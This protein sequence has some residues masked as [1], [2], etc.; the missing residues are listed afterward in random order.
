MMLAEDSVLPESVWCEMDYTNIHAA[1]LFADIQNSVMI[2]STASLCEYDKLINDF[3]AAMLE[4]VRALQEQGVAIGEYRVS[5]DELCLFIYDP[6]EVERN[7]RLDGPAPL[8][9]AERERVVQLSRESNQQLLISALKAA[10][11]L[12]SHWLVQRFNVQ[13]VQSHHAPFELCIG[14]HDGRVILRDRPDGKRRIEGYAVNLAKR[15]QSASRSARYSCIMLSEDACEA[16][17]RSVVAHSQ[18]RQRVFFH[19]HEMEL[20]EM[21]GVAKP[22]PVYELKF[23][24][25]IH[26]PVPPAS[27][28]LHEA[29]FAIDPTCLWS[30]YQL[31]EHHAYT[32]GNWDEAYTIASRAHTFQPRDEKIKLDLA[33]Y[34]FQRKD[35]QMATM[36]CNQAL[37]LNPE[38]DLAYELM[39]LIAETLDDMPAAVDHLRQAVSLSPGSPCN[40]LNLGLALTSMDLY[41]EALH[42]IVEALNIF[43]RYLHQPQV[44]DALAKI[45]KH[46]EL[47]VAL[48]GLIAPKPDEEHQVSTASSTQ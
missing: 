11:Q 7:Y 26:V 39:A 41:T 37:A 43:P 17:S 47:P 45:S 31:I 25:R 27:L 46:M 33:N 15:V 24:H 29:I 8:T 32:E 28:A 38:F 21:K 2:S 6:H 30:Y 10:I 9:G 5:G 18:L 34:Y 20:Y 36:Y 4:I 42:H 1:V 48:R 13:R 44:Q 12:K 19:R 3:Q 14:I 23:C 35:L 22:Q 40:H 16:L